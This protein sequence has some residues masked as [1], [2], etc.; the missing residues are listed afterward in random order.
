MVATVWCPLL[1]IY[2]SRLGFRLMKVATCFFLGG[3][4]PNKML[5]KV[6]SAE[7]ETKLY[8]QQ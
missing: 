5:S 8:G 4:L 7:K 6:H 1:R 3:V 2:I